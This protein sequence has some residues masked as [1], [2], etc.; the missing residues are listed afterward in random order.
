MCLHCESICILFALW[1]LVFRDVKQHSWS[2][3]AVHIGPQ[4]AIKSSNCFNSLANKISKI[5]MFVAGNQG[6]QVKLLECSEA[7]WYII[8][9]VL[10]ILNVFVHHNTK[11]NPFKSSS[12]Y[13]VQFS[14][15][16]FGAFGPF[17]LLIPGLINS[18]RYQ[19]K[20]RR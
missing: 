3:F 1:K 9:V 10:I 18:L 7:G 20:G 12:P 6:L 4:A 5:V 2:Q 17:K 16:Q 15:F 13:K 14:L 8:Y 19:K 11:F